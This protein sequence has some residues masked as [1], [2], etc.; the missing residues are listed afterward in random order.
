MFG[1]H[2]GSLA[3]VRAATDRF[4]GSANTWV[5]EGNTQPKG[6][7]SRDS[8]EYVLVLAGTGSL[9]PDRAMGTYHSATYYVIR[10]ASY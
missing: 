5:S 4:K 8:A 3:N 6:P 7:G 9:L 1:G 2:R 10:I